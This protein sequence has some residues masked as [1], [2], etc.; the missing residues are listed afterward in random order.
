MEDLCSFVCKH[1][2]F[3]YDFLCENSLQ[4]IAEACVKAVLEIMD[5]G[6]TPVCFFSCSP[7]TLELTKQKVFRIMKKFKSNFSSLGNLFR[8]TPDEVLTQVAEFSWN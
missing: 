6:S 3:D 5:I 4:N 7:I 2:V 1:L 8:F